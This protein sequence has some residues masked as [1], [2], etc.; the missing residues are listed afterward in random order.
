LT[1]SADWWSYEIEDAIRSLDEQLI[2]ENWT[3][4]TTGVLVCLGGFLSAKDRIGW[5]AQRFSECV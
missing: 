3:P 1:L 5:P 2:A 4:R